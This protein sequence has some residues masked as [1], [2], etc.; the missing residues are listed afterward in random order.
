M[1][2][3]IHGGFGNTKG[4]KEAKTETETLS[5][6]VNNTNNTGVENG[7]KLPTN[8]SQLKHIFSNREGHFSDTPDNR[9]LLT[10]LANDKSKFVGTDKYGNSWNAETTSDGSQNWV[11]YQNGTINEGGRNT[12]PRAWN[13][14]TGYNNNPVKRRKKK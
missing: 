13:D 6:N 3:G 1:G 14:E 5:I 10:N 4:S 2:A 8:D 12:I 9:K 7:T 11:R